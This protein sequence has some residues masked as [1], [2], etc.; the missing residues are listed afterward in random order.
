ML[1]ALNFVFLIGDIYVYELEIFCLIA[2]IILI[3]FGYYNFMTLLEPFIIFQIA[4]L[5]IY[6]IVA[7]IYF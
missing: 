3:F 2:D 6:D 5:G 7:M 1:S 4:F